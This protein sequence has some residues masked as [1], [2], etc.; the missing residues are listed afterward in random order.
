MSNK[1]FDKEKYIKELETQ[2]EELKFISNTTKEYLF[3]LESDLNEKNKKITHLQEKIKNK[4]KKIKS[5]KKDLKAAKK[6]NST[7]NTSNNSKT[8][9]PL[10]KIFKK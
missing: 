8:S 10:R 9:S 5:M 4:N 7:L 1:E 6:E 2:I 3:V